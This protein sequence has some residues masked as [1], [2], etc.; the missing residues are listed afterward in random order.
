L[1]AM[2]INQNKVIFQMIT[3]TFKKVAAIVAVVVVVVIAEMVK[4]RNHIMVV[5]VVVITTIKC[6]II[7]A[8]PTIKTKK[9]SIIVA[10]K[11]IIMVIE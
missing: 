6:V 1:A 5:M 10:M 2:V 11:N 4:A 9:D 3:V 8:E 7:H